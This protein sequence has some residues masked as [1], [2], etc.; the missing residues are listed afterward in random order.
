[1]NEFSDPRGDFALYNL[2]LIREVEAREAD[3][4]NM[5]AQISKK[6]GEKV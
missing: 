2:D 3:A 5:K 6:I 1:M 4:E